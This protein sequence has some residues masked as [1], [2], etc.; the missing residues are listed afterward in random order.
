MSLVLVFFLSD[1]RWRPNL[2]ENEMTPRWSVELWRPEQHQ[3]H[4]LVHGAPP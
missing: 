4:A 2:K 1:R 3:W